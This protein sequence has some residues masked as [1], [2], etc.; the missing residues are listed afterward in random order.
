MVKNIVGAGVLSLPGGLALCSDS[1]RGLLVAVIWIAGLAALFGYFCALIARSCAWQGATSYRSGWEA[2]Q[3]NHGALAVS[4]TQALKPGLGNLAYAVILSQ[5]GTS[6]LASVGVTVSR[7]LVLWVLTIGAFV[8]LC[9]LKDLQ[10][11]APFSASRG[12]QGFCTRSWP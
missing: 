8:P 12:R 7:N 4:L 11:L 2:T 9:L 3:G 5:T 1:P 6:L 10:V